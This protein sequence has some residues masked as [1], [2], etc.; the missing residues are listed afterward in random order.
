MLTF[1]KS[2]AHTNLYFVEQDG[3]L[4][5]S[6][7]KREMWTVRGSRV[8]WDAY[9]KGVSKGSAQTRQEAAL[10]LTASGV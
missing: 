3:Q 9:R 2:T 4:L 7:Q 10:I 8:M 6:V 1:R 5:G